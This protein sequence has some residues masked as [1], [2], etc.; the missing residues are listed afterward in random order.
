MSALKDLTGNKYGKLLVVS[1][2]GRDKRHRAKWTVLCECGKSSVALSSNLLRGHTTSCGC[3]KGS[4]IYTGDTPLERGREWWKAHSVQIN[5]KRRIR[6]QTDPHYKQKIR[7]AAKKKWDS[8]PVYRKRIIACQGKIAKTPKGKIN[9]HMRT[10]IGQTISEGKNN[11]AWERLVG[12]T[13]DQLMRHLEKQFLPGMTWENH[14]R[15]GWHID[16]KT[17]IAA[18]NFTTTRD[19]DFKRC[20]ALNNLRPLWEKENLSKGAR[21]DKPF[22]PSLRMA[23]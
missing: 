2:A 6:Y 9:K 20:W 3:M 14:G 4:P 17:P 23:L 11:R 7:E 15:G 22:Q 18:F 16:H 12:Y 21:I 19:L 10:V 5:N 13:A 1:D 8:D